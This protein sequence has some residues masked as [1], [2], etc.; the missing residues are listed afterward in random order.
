MSDE[1]GRRAPTLPGARCC[2]V[3]GDKPDEKCTMHQRIES[4]AHYAINARILSDNTLRLYTPK[5]KEERKFAA[6]SNL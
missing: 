5:K 3:T 4:C 6:I 2:F 1:R